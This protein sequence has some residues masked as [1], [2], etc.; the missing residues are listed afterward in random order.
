VKKWWL[1]FIGRHLNPLTLRLAREG[2]S[3]GPMTFWIVRHIGRKSGTTYE[4][5]I[6]LAPVDGG[7]IAEL[8]YGD[9]VQ[10]YQNVVA[11]GGCTIVRGGTETRVVAVE[12][13]PTA[14]GRAAFGGFARVVLTLLRRREFRFLR[15][16]A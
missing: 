9:K 7:F 15:A 4:T 2:K 8:T 6:M 11:A 10:W 16:A 13:Y 1:G 14:A 5:P 3:H 12:P